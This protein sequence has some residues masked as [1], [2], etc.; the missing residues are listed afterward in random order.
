MTINNMLPVKHTR[1]C[2]KTQETI[3]QLPAKYTIYLQKITRK[4]IHNL[5]HLQ[6][7]TWQELFPSHTSTHFLSFPSAFFAENSG[8]YFLNFQYGSGK[9]FLDCHNL[10]D[11]HNFEE[12]VNEHRVCLVYCCGKWS[13]V[14]PTALRKIT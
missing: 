10:N 4:Y 3:V 5:Q 1:D 9:N 6:I 12:T 7:L 11:T 14:T 2:T 13:L 8:N